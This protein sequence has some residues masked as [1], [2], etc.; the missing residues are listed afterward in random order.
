MDNS[1]PN[2][3]LIDETP[4]KKTTNILEQQQIQMEYKKELEAAKERKKLLDQ[5]LSDIE[6]LNVMFHEL[7]V[8]INEQQ[9]IIG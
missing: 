1:H 2:I 6:D 5:L 3:E 7:E 8:M 4:T 9:P